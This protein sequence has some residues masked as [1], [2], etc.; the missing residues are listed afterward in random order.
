MRNYLK[1]VE[2]ME[3]KREELPNRILEEFNNE[4]ISGKN[5]NYVCLY[6]NGK[7]VGLLEYTRKD[8]CW[9]GG[10]EIKEEFRGKGYGKLL[11]EYFI[12]KMK[13]EGERFIC[14][15]VLRKSKPKIDK[16]LDE[17]KEKGII[18][19]YDYDDP[20]EEYWNSERV[21]LYIYL[22]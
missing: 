9:L 6:E 4:I 10:I 11:A 20:F 21:P 19:D 2:I 14:G 18:A 13:N 16:I 3:L 1:T 7:L 5:E 15:E 8:S 17:I 22:K 12:N